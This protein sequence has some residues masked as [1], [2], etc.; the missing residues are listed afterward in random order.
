MSGNESG[1]K[2]GELI[3]EL[4]DRSGVDTADVNVRVELMD[5]AADTLAYLEDKCD[6]HQMQEEGL[7]EDVTELVA[8]LEFAH[9]AFAALKDSSAKCDAE[10]IDLRAEVAYLLGEA[11][12]DRR[13]FQADVAI[14][15]GKIAGELLDLEPMKALKTGLEMQIDYEEGKK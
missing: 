9:K 5:R 14:A 10:R 15:L 3:A 8:E 11:V 6:W 12:E 4:R 7:R 2:V 1:S 13:R